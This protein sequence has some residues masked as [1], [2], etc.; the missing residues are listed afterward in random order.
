MY[1][2]YIRCYTYGNIVVCKYIIWFYSNLYFCQTHIR[3]SL[4]CIYSISG[5]THMEN[6]LS[7]CSILKLMFTNGKIIVY[8]FMIQFYSYLYLCQAYSLKKDY[9]SNYSQEIHLVCNWPQS[10]IIGGCWYNDD[11]S[12]KCDQLTIPITSCHQCKI[13]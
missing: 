12:W 8:K 4:L 10:S 9:L 1:L 5:V 2:F 3:T 13:E 7:F 11:R 6:D